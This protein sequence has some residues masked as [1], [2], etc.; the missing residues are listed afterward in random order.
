MTQ[1]N[2]ALV[3]FFL[4]IGI[5]FTC[6]ARQNFEKTDNKYIPVSQ[7]LY[8]TVAHLDSIFFDAFNNQNI[9]IQKEMFSTD[10]EFFHDAGGLATYEQVIKNTQR[11]FDMNNGLKRTLVPGSM[12]VYPIKDYGALQIGRH[13]FCHM[14]NGKDDCGTFKFIN[15]WQKKDG[16]WQLSRVISYDH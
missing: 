3:M 6:S 11:L 8:D 4:T 13:R 1:T 9:E 15:V 14:E 16:T 5:C 10:V 2:K 12:E 7:A